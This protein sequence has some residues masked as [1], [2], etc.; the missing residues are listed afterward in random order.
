[1][2]A[3]GY[4][5]E[6]DKSFKEY[7]HPTGIIIVTPEGKISRYFMGIYYSGEYRIPGGKTTLRLSLLD[8]ADGK[9][10][11]LLD[12]LT[13]FCYRFDHMKGGYSFNV[14]LAVKAGGILTL[15]AIGTFVFVAMR[16]ERKYRQPVPQLH[17]DRREPMAGGT[18]ASL[19]HND[20]LPSGES[21]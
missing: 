1:M 2:S 12:N 3:I 14:L 17:E 6:F 9:G 13:R 21:A 5:Y 11:S 20:G 16:R 10:G 18:A 15:L 8:A 4:R 7:N 19:H